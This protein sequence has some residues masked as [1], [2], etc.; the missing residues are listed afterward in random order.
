MVLSRFSS[1]QLKTIFIK[2]G[3]LNFPLFPH[4]L[5]SLI[6]L[7]IPFG[8]PL[9]S[10]FSVIT[11][12]NFIKS[13]ANLRAKQLVFIFNCISPFSLFPTLEAQCTKAKKPSVPHQTGNKYALCLL[14][15]VANKKRGSLGQIDTLIKG[16]SRS[17]KPTGLANSITTSPWNFHSNHLP[18]RKLPSK[19]GQFHLHGHQRR[20]G[21]PVDLPTPEIL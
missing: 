9:H 1:S 14:T 4:F 5:P 21:L 16:S 2:S 20:L 7:P 15:H 10:F 13:R 11:I 17:E 6:Q 8:H 12:I 18:P 19:N 3:S